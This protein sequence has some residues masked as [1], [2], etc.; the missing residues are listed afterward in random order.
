MYKEKKFNSSV[1]LLRSDQAENHS[2]ST[3]YNIPGGHKEPQGNR[4]LQASLTL[5]KIHIHEAIKQTLKKNDVHSRE[6][7]VKRKTRLS[8]KNTALEQLPNT[9][10]M[11]QK[12]FGKNVFL[13][14]V[15]ESKVKNK[16]KK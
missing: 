13:S 14:T 12:T 1:P 11:S 15:D 7:A 6:T 5:A 2:I 4:D 10:W 3:T 9:T 8:K 16:N